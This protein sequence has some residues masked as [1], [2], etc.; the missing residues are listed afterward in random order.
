[1]SSYLGISHY[2]I[3]PPPN[4]QDY[5]SKK[6]KF[7]SGK[8]IKAVEA[9]IVADH[10]WDIKRLREIDEERQNTGEMAEQFECGIRTAV[11]MLQLLQIKAE[12]RADEWRLTHEDYARKYGEKKE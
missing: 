7:K 11:K 3:G 8:Y 4:W 5:I 6:G 9:W 1:M 10:L 12:R 2:A